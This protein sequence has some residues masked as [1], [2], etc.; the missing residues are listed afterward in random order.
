GN[1]GSSTTGG[2][3]SGGTSGVS[4]SAGPKETGAGAMDGVLVGSLACLA[5][6]GLT[7][8]LAGKKVSS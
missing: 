8:R 4:A 3:V 1:I 5:L 6:V 2:S 7:R